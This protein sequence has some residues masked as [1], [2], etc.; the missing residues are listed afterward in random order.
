MTTVTLLQVSYL[1]LSQHCSNQILLEKKK[2]STNQTIC[3]L[4]KQKQNKMDLGLQISSFTSFHI[5]YCT[6]ITG[7]MRSI[8]LGVEEKITTQKLNY[9]ISSIYR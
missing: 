9:Q 6:S 2:K 1:R 3:S 7:Q 4:K 8:H 5:S